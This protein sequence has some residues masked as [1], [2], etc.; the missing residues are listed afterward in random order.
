MGKVLMTFLRINLSKSCSL[1][2][3][4]VNQDHTF[5]CSKQ[6]LISGEEL[7]RLKIGGGEC[8]VPALPP[9]LTSK[10]TDRRPL[11]FFNSIYIG[12]HASSW[13]ILKA[14]CCT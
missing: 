9:T 8:S 3:I 11:T 2:S 14:K 13:T 4:K 7:N 10:T 5:L 6:N 1:N 12:W